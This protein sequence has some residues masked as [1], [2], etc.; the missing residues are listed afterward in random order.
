[1]VA[2]GIR[3]IGGMRWPPKGSGDSAHLPTRAPCTARAI[4]GRRAPAGEQRAS[5]RHTDARTPISFPVAAVNQRGLSTERA[6][7]FAAD[8]PGYEPNPDGS[9]RAP[10]SRSRN[11]ERGV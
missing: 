6:R 5:V 9:E 10:K 1:M 7:E 11:R 4:T 2:A 3:G 8:N